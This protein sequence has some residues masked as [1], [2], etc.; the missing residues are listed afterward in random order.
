MS[1]GLSLYPEPVVEAQAEALRTAFYSL[2]NDEE[3]VKAITIGSNHLKEVR[4]RFKVVESMLKEV[5]DA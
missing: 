4:Y 5:F 2:M 1:T 3:F